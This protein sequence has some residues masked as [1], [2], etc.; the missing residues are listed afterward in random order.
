MAPPGPQL[1]KCVLMETATLPPGV[2]SCRSWPATWRSTSP[3]RWTTRWRTA[4]RPH[5][6]LSG[7]AGLVGPGGHAARRGGRRAAAD[8]RAPAARGRVR[9]KPGRHPPGG[10]QRHVR[11]T[12]GRRRCRAALAGAAA[13]R[14]RSLAHALLIGSPPVLTWPDTDLEAPLWPVAEAAYRLLTGPEPVR[15]KRC[16]GC[17]WLFLYQSRNGSRRWCADGRL[18]PAREDPPLR[19]Q[20]RRIPAPVARRPA[21]LRPF[22]AALRDRL[23]I[24]RNTGR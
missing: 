16:A 23:V 12:G 4:V 15:L 3:T 13:V 8:R 19:D 20:A 11:R 1:V 14:R 6:R 2:G 10:A 22:R 21:P 24:V 7:A 9:G 18:R 5:R 17:P